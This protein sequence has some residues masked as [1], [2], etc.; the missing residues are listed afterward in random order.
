MARWAKITVIAISLTLSLTFVWGSRN[1]HPYDEDDSVVH[2]SDAALT[3]KESNEV[4]IERDHNED[5]LCEDGVEDYGD[6]DGARPTRSEPVIT[7]KVD[8]STLLIVSTLDGTISAL[9]GDQNG[10]VLWKVDTGPGSLLSSSISKV[11]LSSQGK[12]VRLIPS[13]E[14]GLYKFDGEAIE[15]I[16]ITADS[17]L[18]GNYQ[19]ADDLLITGGKEVRTYGIDARTGHLQYSCS[20]DGCQVDPTA[21]SV[22]G[23]FMVIRRHNQ[24]VRAIE[25]RSGTERW[26]FSVGRLEAS[27]L[28]STVFSQCKENNMDDPDKHMDC[29]LNESPINDE[30][31]LPAV[32]TDSMQFKVVVPDGVVCAVHPQ[33][34]GAVL[35][36]HK[37]ESPVVHVWQLI[38]GKLVPLN[39]FGSESVPAIEGQP[40]NDEL[41]SAVASPLLYV[42]I[43]NQQL[44]VQESNRFADRLTELLTHSPQSTDKN[45]LALYRIPWK[46]LSATSWKDVEERPLVDPAVLNSES[47]IE[48][49][50]DPEDTAVIVRHQTDYPFSRGFYLFEDQV[51][52]QADQTIYS[53]NGTILEEDSDF[54]ES[55]WKSGIHIV[56]LWYYWREVTVFSLIT[57]V[58]VHLVYTLQVVKVLKREWNRQV[59]LL[60]PAVYRVIYE[61]IRREQ[62]DGANAA[63]LD[64]LAIKDNS[65]EVPVIVV[66][67]DSVP[68]ATDAAPYVS[69]YLTDFEPIQCLGR[70][71]FGLVFE[72]RNRLDDCHYAV[73]RI[74]LPNSQEARE[75]VMR[76][77]KALAKLDNPHIV[78]Y[79]H[80]WI[81]CPPPGW[82]ENE[83]AAWIDCDSLT[84]PTTFNSKESDDEESSLGDLK[85]LNRFSMRHKST[86]NDSSFGI[87]FEDS[88][89]ASATTKESCRLDLSSYNSSSPWSE[90]SASGGH[91]DMFQLESEVP[92]TKNL[93]SVQS[94]QIDRKVDAKMF[95]YIQMQ[96]CRKE[97]LREWLREHGSHRDPQQVLQMFNEIIRAVEY[98]H[99]Q[100]MIHRDLKPSNIF[101]APDGAMKIGDFGLVT[102]IAE[103][104]FLH[105]PCGDNDGGFVPFR[106][107]T[108]QVGTQ[109]YMSPEQIEGKPY[110]HK[111]DIYSLGLIFFELLWPLG[112]QMEQV[113]VISQLRKLKFPVGFVDKYPEEAV[114]LRKMLSRNPD[115]R[116]TTFGTRAAPPLSSLQD[117]SLL[118]MPLYL[119]YNL[120]RPRTSSSQSTA[121]TSSSSSS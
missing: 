22:S 44:Y 54:E 98:V 13:L 65:D 114:L 15:P 99:L 70:G 107:H 1:N 82:Q 67:N 50:S 19:S 101:F 84:G 72:V 91:S 121:R 51:P 3:E 62:R 108:D 14:G 74:Q 42:G 2:L 93:C 23:E 69:R 4:F 34:K 45:A 92:A 30:D 56:P 116:P 60:I 43:H 104:A 75:K 5:L 77:V 86:T 49:D 28:H 118:E 47:P 90:A 9:N 40:S 10:S 85:P 48:C 95:L 66:S 25:P 115:E 17:L 38:D 7:N 79:F 29:F 119:H 88:D 64:A 113:T 94:S 31:D 46:P 80:A 33:N 61:K 57:A 110:N 27:L 6:S 37:F 97:S 78:R 105:S 36:Q 32:A 76:E 18:H 100:G 26:N 63:A 71:G 24:V 112:T 103:E 68:A 81:E 87:V 73:K 58:A 39:L 109:L 106:R 55:L 8:K 111:V 16:P 11:E 41:P 117:P 83:D 53:E 21:T 102:A 35:W 120:Q 52:S 20:V 96:L 59:Q 89:A 12:L